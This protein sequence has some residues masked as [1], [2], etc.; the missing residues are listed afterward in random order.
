M[1]R[2]ERIKNYDFPSQNITAASAGVTLYSN[3]PI[4]G[5]VLEV[6]TKFN[7]GGSIAITESGT[8]RIYYNKNNISGAAWAVSN[9]VGT[10][11]QE[12]G[13][14]QTTSMRHPV[15][16]SVIVLTTGSLVS[17]T[18]ATLEVGIKYR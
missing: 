2:G 6:R 12:S 16:D 14:V 9:L 3:Y 4:N 13:G 15:S 5:E 17:G 11:V 18:T 8:S 10:T 1:T 7:Q